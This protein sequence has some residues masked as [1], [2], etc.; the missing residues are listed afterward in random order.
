M[1]TKLFPHPG[2]TVML[3]IV[4]ILI[5]NSL[6][7]G[8]FLLGL[9]LAT[10]I[11]VFTAPF[12]PDRPRLRFGWAM[13]GY[14]GIVLYDIVV[15]NFHVAKLILFRRNRDLNSR[16]MT[17]PLD[18]RSAEAITVLAGTISLTPGT[19]SADVSADGRYLLVHTLDTG[20]VAHEIA[21]IKARYEARLQRI[22]R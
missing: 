12:W 19:V 22:F 20:N 10:V 15:A 16:W 21:H 4:W 3:L 7:A 13:L 2:L 11:P 8:G 17:I 1:L 9:L 18:L 5:Q 14:L 6:T